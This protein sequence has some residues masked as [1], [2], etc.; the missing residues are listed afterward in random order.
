MATIASYLPESQIITLSKDFPALTDPEKLSGFTNPLQFGVFFHEWIHFLHNIST[1]NGFSVFCT[2]IILWSNFRWAM[3]NQDVCIGSSSMDQ[4]NIE[5][6]KRFYSYIYSNRKMHNCGLPTHIKV[7]DLSFESAE[8]HNMEVADDSVV[9]TSLIKCT[10][11][12][13]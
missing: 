5:F 13:S 7:N 2:Q 9:S 10:I 3:D 1:I 6:N 4:N 8:I 11:I 12:Y